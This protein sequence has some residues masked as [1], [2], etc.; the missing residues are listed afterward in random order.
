MS[1]PPVH[2]HLDFRGKR[3]GISEALTW[4]RCRFMTLVG[5]MTTL[6]LPTQAL[7]LG[8][9]SCSQGE[10]EIFLEINEHPNDPGLRCEVALWTGADERQPLWQLDDDPAICRGHAQ[11][12]KSILEGQQ[13]Q[14]GA[15]SAKRMLAPMPKVSVGEVPRPAQE[16]AKLTRP[17]P[18]RAQ[19]S[20]PKPL[21][22]LIK[23][24]SYSCRRDEQRRTLWAETKSPEGHLPCQILW[25]EGD[26]SQPKLMWLARNQAGFCV[27]KL[28][29]ALDRWAR[30]GWRCQS[31]DEIDISPPPSTTDPIENKTPN[32]T[33]PT[34][35]NPLPS[36]L[37]L[38]TEDDQKAGPLSRL[39][40]I[41]RWLVPDDVETAFSASV[42]SNLAWVGDRFDLRAR[43]IE[44][45]ER[46][47]DIYQ[48]RFVIW[49]G[50]FTNIYAGGHPDAVV[51][52][53]YRDA[54]QEPRFLLNVYRYG[55]GHFQM[56]DSLIL[57]KDWADKPDRLRGYYLLTEKSGL[58]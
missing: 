42:E 7:A 5:L 38:L 14:C 51:L 34:P 13:W 19:P 4:N 30:A 46:L 33:D 39:P 10:I 56:A 37:G 40:D 22:G 25:T 49:D 20:R 24:S 50:L 41:A 57:D 3:P 53:A 6:G 32:K 15:E 44:D 27:A 12:F 58:N 29:Q 55:D 28:P 11:N 9:Y 18:P 43:L 16:T 48:S 54:N 31:Q 17:E 52:V 26:Q 23:G 2:Q 1:T 8:G 36:L 21:T 45:L 47:A 35:I